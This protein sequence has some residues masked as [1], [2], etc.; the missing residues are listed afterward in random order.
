VSGRTQANARL[1]TRG[2]LARWSSAGGRPTALALLRLNH[3]AAV[4]G[5]IFTRDGRLAAGIAQE[6]LF[7]PGTRR[8]GPLAE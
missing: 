2:D 6:S 3:G 7:R 8:R 5:R 4:T 1:G